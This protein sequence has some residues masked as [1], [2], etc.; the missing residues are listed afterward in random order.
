VGHSADIS[1][2][3]RALIDLKESLLDKIKHSVFIADLAERIISEAVHTR[4]HSKILESKLSFSSDFMIDKGEFFSDYQGYETI[5]QFWA[6]MGIE[7]V[8]VGK[9]YLGKE[10]FAF[11]FGTGSK[12]VVFHGAI[13]AREWIGPAAVSY[14]GMKLATDSKYEDL[15]AAFTFYVIPVLNVC[16]LIL[17]LAR[18]MDMSIHAPKG[19][20]CTAKI[21]K[22]Q[23]DV[24]EQTLTGT[25]DSIGIKEARVIEPV[26]R[27]QSILSTL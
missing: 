17:I 12:S 2:S 1:F 21:C 18:L 8:V 23:R 22:L 5:V 4:T 10:I 15:R 11:K 20:E 14:I 24:W 7:K 3:P 27:Y 25:L 19:N 6:T 9:T 26:L 16:I 13:H